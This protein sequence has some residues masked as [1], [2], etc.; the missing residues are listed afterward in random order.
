MTAVRVRPSEVAVGDCMQLIGMPQPGLVLWTRDAGDDRA[1]GC[2]IMEIA[3]Q[4]APEPLRQPERLTV[5][6]LR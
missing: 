5:E 6:V 2:P 3:V 1:W 4:G